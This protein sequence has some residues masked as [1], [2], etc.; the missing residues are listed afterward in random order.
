MDTVRAADQQ[1][2]EFIRERGQRFCAVTKEPKDTQ[3]LL[4]AAVVLGR[5]TATRSSF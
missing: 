5:S 1:A 3:Y 2:S 4:F